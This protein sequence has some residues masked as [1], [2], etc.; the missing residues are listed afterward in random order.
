MKAS[1]G[2][3]TLSEACE[4]KPPKSEV[5]RRL[6]DKESVSFVPMEDLGI[7]QK[8]VSGNQVR[9]LSAVVGGYT[10]FA[11]G[12]VLLAKITP[13]FENGKLGIAHKLENGVGFGSSEY[14]V[15]RPG[16][17]LDAQWLYY[18][19]SRD[20]FR[21]EGEARMGGA[22]G[23][24]RVAKEFIESYQVPLPS[25]SEQHRIVALL[26]EAFAGIATAKANAEKSLRNA[27]EAAESG[28]QDV[29]D[30][31]E[32]VEVALEEAAAKDCSLSYGIVQPGNDVDN[33]LP[34][35]R[36]VDLTRRVVVP[37]GLKRIRPDLADGYQRTRLQG[38]ELL[39]CVRGTTGTIAIASQDLAG[40]N[41]TRGIVPIRFKPELVSPVLGYHLMRSAGV[42]SQIREKTYGAALM[43]INIGDL[44]K[45]SL[46]IPPLEKQK[47]LAA[48]L[49]ALYAE[50]SHLQSL[51]TRKLAALD[52]LKQSLLHQAFSGNL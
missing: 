41:V 46:R 18:Y 39:L 28:A 5:R 31:A 15:F 50:A 51:Y 49:D 23:H 48:R 16:P 22:V 26:D 30:S 10:Y 27:K 8:F 40:A 9:E 3:Q 14:I 1:W 35:V 12:D 45:L 7:D 34:I 44:R 36:P 29:L 2:V 24:K 33:G 38:G 32:G 47:E 42:Q 4:I 37:D 13:C 6:S 17:K 11:D 52:E 21:T 20:S 25:V 19:L 43:Q